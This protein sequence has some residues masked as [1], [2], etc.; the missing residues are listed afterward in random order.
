MCC[1]GGLEDLALDA[2]WATQ[3]SLTPLLRY[4][5][6]DVWD[7]DGYTVSA[8]EYLPPFFSATPFKSF[9]KV[10]GNALQSISGSM[11]SNLAAPPFSLAITAAVSETLLANNRNTVREFGVRSPLAEEVSYVVYKPPNLR[12]PSVIIE[13]VTE[14]PLAS[15]P[16]LTELSIIRNDE[17]NWPQLY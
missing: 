9:S 7:G 15:L 17:S 2:L 13:R 14:S 10:R 12:D 5:P 6:S 8:P 4:F 3:V 16:N 11:L 1:C